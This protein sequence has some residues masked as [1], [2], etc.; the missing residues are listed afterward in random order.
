MGIFD[1]IMHTKMYTL[2]IP[3]LCAA[4]LF[5]SFDSRQTPGIIAEGAELEKISGGF[6]FTEGPA[7]DANGNV[8][9]TDQPNDRILKWSPGDGVV[10]WMQPC[11]RSNGLCFDAGGMLWACADENNALWKIDRDRNVAI[12]VD[13]YEGKKLNGP[14]DVW[15]TP[16][17]GAYFTDPFYKRPYWDRES[18]EMDCHGVYYVAP[19]ATEAVRLVDDLVKPNGIIGSPDGKTLYVTDISGKKTYRYSIKDDGSLSEKKLLCEMGSYGMTLDDKGNLYL[20]GHGVTVF[21][22]AGNQIAHIEVPEKWTANVCFGG[23]DMDYL[24]ITASECLYR[25]RMAVRGAGSQ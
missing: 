5:M 9:F 10:T 12:V 25:I 15:V 4:L 7:A 14:N 24:F 2:Q 1:Q 13:Q 8:F 6:S 18:M 21:D 17:G 20:T 3:M 16:E 23:K 22:G 19:G 11:G